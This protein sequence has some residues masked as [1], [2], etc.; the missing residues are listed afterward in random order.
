MFEVEFG[1]L[2]FNIENSEQ[3]LCIVVAGKNEA[4]ALDDFIHKALDYLKN[5]DLFFDEADEYRNCV[6]ADAIESDVKW[7]YQIIEGMNRKVS[8]VIDKPIKIMTGTMTVFDAA[9]AIE[10]KDLFYYICW[11]TTA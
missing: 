6:F 7:L 10:T 9:W 5:S 11:Y 4:S 1:N 3:A 8:F 2:A